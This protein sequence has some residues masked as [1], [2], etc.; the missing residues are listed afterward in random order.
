MESTEGNWFSTTQKWVVA[1]SSK[2]EWVGLAFL[3]FMVVAAVVDVVGA[4]LF[5][6]P[7]PGSTEITGLFQ[8]MAIGS[9]LAFSKI[10]GRQIYVGFLIDSVKGRPKVVL[11]VIRSALSLM[12]WGI[13]A[14]M[15]FEYAIKLMRRGTETFLLGVPLYPFAFWVSVC[16]CVP[17]CLLLILDLVRPIAVRGQE[18]GEED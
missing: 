12:F 5:K 18:G 7:L 11:E 3:V 6:A 8:I 15:V 4:K 9:G 2:L 13:A 1:V 16:C 10:A 17:M 14:W